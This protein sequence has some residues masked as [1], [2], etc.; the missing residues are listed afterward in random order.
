MF[1]HVDPLQVYPCIRVHTA[2]ATPQ[3]PEP[4]GPPPAPPSLI[5]AHNEAAGIGQTL[6]VFA[7]RPSWLRLCVVADNCSDDTAAVARQAGVPRWWSGT[8]CS[9]RAKGMRCMRACRPCPA[10]PP[11]VVLVLDADCLTRMPDMAALSLAYGASGPCR[12]PT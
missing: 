3:P 1:V 12:R 4:P 9:T 6:A 5:P 10:H 2:C 8:T 11:G 7:Q